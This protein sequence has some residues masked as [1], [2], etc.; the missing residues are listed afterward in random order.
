MRRGR[1][2][3]FVSHGLASD[4]VPD[5]QDPATRHR[6]VLPWQE[7]EEEPHAAVLRWYTACTALRRSLL[8][9]G[10]TH[11]VDVDV[12][13]D[14]AARWVVVAHAPA[15]RA[16]HAVVANLSPRPTAVPVDGAAELLLAWQPDGTRLL[17]DAVHLPPESAA[18][19]RLG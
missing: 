12:A 9:P 7:V 19:V 15:G 4:D 13:V 2:D 1:L 17:G 16:A 11:L 6:S 14:E 3:E 5:P 8:P 10:P 18:V